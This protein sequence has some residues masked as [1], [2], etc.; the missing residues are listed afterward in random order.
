M[1]LLICTLFLI[2]SVQAQNRRPN[3]AVYFLDACICKDTQ[4]L[5]G[6]NCEMACTNKETN[7]AAL[8]YANFHVK[9]KI[10]TGWLENVEGWC[11]RQL[12]YRGKDPKCLLEVKD[13]Y[14][15]Y[16][17]LE[18]ET[19]KNTLVANVDKFKAG[20]SYKIHL[21]EINSGARSKN[22]WITKKPIEE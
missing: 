21:L 13:R 12:P 6:G 1:K 8:L 18:V 22:Y 4:S 14:G 2:T 10:S 9:R 19:H 20:H 3:H 5:S 11:N 16:S 7:G 15:H 17:Y